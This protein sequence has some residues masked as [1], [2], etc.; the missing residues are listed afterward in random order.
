MAIKIG[1]TRLPPEAIEKV[2]HEPQRQM[3]EAT[4]LLND[5]LDS[6]GAELEQNGITKIASYETVPMQDN[7]AVASPLANRMVDLL[8]K[9]DQYMP[10]LSTLEILEVIPESE[11]DT[12]R[13]RAKRAVLGLSSSALRLWFGVQRRMQEAD[14]TAA[15]AAASE[16]QQRICPRRRH[17]KTPAHRV[18]LLRRSGP[19]AARDRRRC[20]WVRAAPMPCPQRRRRRQSCR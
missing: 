19:L 11:A 4:K 18:P 13:A 2:N 8:L 20:P 15:R 12:R 14:R 16:A 17:P 5:A 6:A 7:V 3:A 10:L 9:L 1:R